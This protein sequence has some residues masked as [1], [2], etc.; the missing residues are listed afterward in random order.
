[1][2]PR[3]AAVEVLLEGRRDGDE[4]RRVADI[5][6]RNPDLE[7]PVEIRVDADGKEIPETRKASDVY[8]DLV[9]EDTRTT[10]MFTCMT[11]GGRA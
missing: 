10:D 3:A 5:L 1:M 2:G 11:G 7:I 4:A 6:A 8:D 9:E